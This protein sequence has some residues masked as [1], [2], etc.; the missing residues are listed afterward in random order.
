MDYTSNILITGGAGYIG[1]HAC[2]ILSSMGY[3][4]IVFD[5]LSVGHETSVKWGPFIKGDLKDKRALSKSLSNQ[6]TN[7]NDSIENNRSPNF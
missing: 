2:K 6:F 4:P 3:T 1:S 5:N 7:K